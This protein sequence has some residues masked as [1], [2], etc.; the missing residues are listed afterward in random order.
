MKL[1]GNT[2]LI[3][4]GSS[5]I[6]LELVK[7][8]LKKENQVI[9]CGRSVEKLEKAKRELPAVH[10][11]RCDLS[12]QSEREKLYSWTVKNHSICNVLINNAGYANRM[13][14][15][16]DKDY[17]P[18]AEHEMQTNFIAPM[19]LIQLFLPHLEKQGNSYIIN[20]TTGLVYLPKAVEPV[21]CASK[22]ALHS[23]TQPLR[24]Q[25][26]DTGVQVIEVL[27]PAVNTSFHHGNVP[28]IAISVGVAVAEIVEGLENDKKEI[29]VAGSKLAYIISRIAPS[30]G[31]RKI[32]QL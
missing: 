15:L 17:L 14:I 24:L 11:F 4:G 27:P 8:L 6:G 32:N 30:F 16:K 12:L 9:I 21:Y 19:S 7:A 2:V 5:G 3:T 25:I 18:L 22:A 20:V 26:K 31:L 10:I 1:K 13:H 29:R 28:K 23:F